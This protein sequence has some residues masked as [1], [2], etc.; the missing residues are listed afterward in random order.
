[1]PDTTYLWLIPAI[2][3]YTAAI[4]DQLPSLARL[5]PFIALTVAITMYFG[6]I[7][8]NQSL[9]GLLYAVGSSMGLYSSIKAIGT[10]NVKSNS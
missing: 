3:G 9:F 7:H 10:I 6:A 1:M 8:L 5:K 2:I 4:E